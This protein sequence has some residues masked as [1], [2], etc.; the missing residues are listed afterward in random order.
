MYAF[1]DFSRGYTRNL[2]DAGKGKSNLVSSAGELPWTAECEAHGS[3]QLVWVWT[4]GKGSPGHDHAQSHRVMKVGGACERT[5]RR[6][7]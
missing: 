3:G 1:E 2:V 6:R 7:G 5:T 4:P